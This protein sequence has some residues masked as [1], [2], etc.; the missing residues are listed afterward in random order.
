MQSVEWLVQAASRAM[1]VSFDHV[2]ARQLAEGA[3]VELQ[4]QATTADTDELIADA[5]LI[6]AVALTETLDGDV[7]GALAASLA[8][9]RARSDDLRAACSLRAASN[10]AL[11]LGHAHRAL[12]ILRDYESVAHAD[13]AAHDADRLRTRAMLRLGRIEEADVIAR[14]LGAADDA[15]WAAANAS[16]RSRVLMAQ[17]V[18]A[19]RWRRLQLVREIFR[20]LA[21]AEELLYGPDV[22][23][24][25]VFRGSFHRDR[26][27]ALLVV[28]DVAEARREL[29]HALSLRSVAGTSTAEIRADLRAVDV[30]DNAEIC[31]GPLAMGWARYQTLR[32][33][34]P[35]R[36]YFE[37]FRALEATLT[38]VAGSHLGSRKGF[39][40][41]HRA[42]CCELA[43][44]NAA[45][46]EAQ[47]RQLSSVRNAI[48]HGTPPSRAA[49]QPLLAD[50]AVAAVRVED[51][52]RTPT[53]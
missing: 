33:R 29:R 16:L 49:I 37:L 50:L 20:E 43:G 11:R 9:A 14:R 42:A 36:A 13:P 5:A 40:S 21:D 32:S 51:V 39:M 4:A 35:E 22:R 53:H 27:H 28:A 30:P 38:E 23:V 34:D 24:H 31:I 52:L 48:A 3:L 2:L 15:H 1:W 46:P 8:H 7:D 17:V 10:Y 44:L 47:A 18:H 41:S 45:L 12:R 25:T 6:R 19:G 26:G